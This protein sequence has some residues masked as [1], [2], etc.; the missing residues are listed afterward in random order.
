MATAEELTD[1]YNQLNRPSATQFRQAL[2]RRGIP[3]RLKDVESFVRSKSERQV[4]GPPPKYTGHIVAFA[5]DDRWMGDLIAFTSRPVESKGKRY[6]HVLVVIDLFTR[7]IWAR[8]L[9][10]VSEATE[11]MAG[12]LA[13]GRKPNRLDTDGG[14]EFAN[15]QFQTMLQTR[16]V[17]HTIKDKD[18]INALATA[19]AAIA[20]LK[21]AIKRRRDAEGGTWL[22]QLEPAVTGYNDTV[23]SATDAPPNDVSDDV[24]FSLMKEAAEDMADNTD[25]IEKRRARLEKAG[26]FRVFQPKEGGLRRRVD[27]DTWSRTVHTVKDF[28]APGRVRDTDDK[29]FLTKLTR[30][31]AKDSSALAVEP[32]RD[33][34]QS[35]LQTLRPYAVALRDLL[36]AGKTLATAARELKA[37]RPNF[38]DALKAAR[39]SFNDFVGRF[40]DLL[41]VENG[42]V[43]ARGQNTLG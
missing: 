39:L 27:A 34:S 36:G 16:G 31:V 3:A 38:T 13:E 21:R 25:Q 6:T 12:I 1:L 37:R 20:S 23:H 10:A 7:F 32:E 14:P 29:V 2:A 11:A 5:K 40:P 35:V 9:Q 8:P 17:Q 18:D 26:A 33:R 42:K 41:R 43:Y 30:P 15:R 22:S 19:D 28:P 4:T 24:A